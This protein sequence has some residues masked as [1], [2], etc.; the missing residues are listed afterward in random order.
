MRSLPAV[1]AW[2]VRRRIF[3]LYGELKL[4]EVEMERGAAGSAD[5]LLARL[6]ALD[7]RASRLRVSRGQSPHAY[8]LRH[9]IRLVRERLEKGQ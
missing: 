2:T 4:V 9:H 5:G 3:R 8:T 6:D 1:Y 7:E